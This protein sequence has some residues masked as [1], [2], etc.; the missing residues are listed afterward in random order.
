MYIC[1]CKRIYLSRGKMFVLWQMKDSSSEHEQN[2]IRKLCNFTQ[3]SL[4][5]EQLILYALKKITVMVLGSQRYKFCAALKWQNRKLMNLQFIAGS[6]KCHKRKF[7]NI[8]T[9]VTIACKMRAT[10]GWWAWRVH[11]LPRC[12]QTETIFASSQS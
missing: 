9:N 6:I 1:L 7:D 3:S 4:S 5:Y 2:T 12:A 10:G 11:P 8:K